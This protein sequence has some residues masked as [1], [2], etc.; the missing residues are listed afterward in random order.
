M[1]QCNAN[2]AE[3]GLD[4]GISISIIALCG[5]YKYEYKY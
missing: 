1:C 5:E 2:R 4:T 3:I